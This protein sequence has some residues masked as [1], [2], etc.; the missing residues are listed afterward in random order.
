MHSFTFFPSA[1]GEPN[2]HSSE[3][4]PVMST[5]SWTPEEDTVLQEGIRQYGQ[6]WNTVSDVCL[7]HRSPEECMHRWN[8]RARGNMPKVRR[9]NSWT[10]EE[11]KLLL[12]GYKMHPKQWAKIATMIPGRTNHQVKQRWNYVLNSDIRN[13][14]WSSEED[15]L[16]LQGFEQFG[17]QWAKICELIPGRTNIQCRNRWKDVLDPSIRNDPWSQEEEMILEDAYSQFGNRWAKIALM[18]PGRTGLQ[19]RD[20]YTRRCS[21]KRKR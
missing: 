5:I 4:M 3:G 10:P 7:P 8:I 19:C 21:D 11:D 12:S 9:K 2:P 14:P 13:G 17:K 16:L 20:R 6:E 15:Q 18:L 1:N